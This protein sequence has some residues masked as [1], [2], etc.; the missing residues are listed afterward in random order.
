MYNLAVFI[1]SF[2]YFSIEVGAVV[3][4]IVVAGII[5]HGGRN[6]GLR[7]RVSWDINKVVI[8]MLLDIN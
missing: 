7:G 1:S 4:G 5:A 3:M 6:S 2:L 8:S